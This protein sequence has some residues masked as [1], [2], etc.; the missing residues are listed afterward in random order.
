M[1]VPESVPRAHLP[2]RWKIAK[3]NDCNRPVGRG[4]SGD[5][6]VINGAVML[7]G[8]SVVSE[9]G[10]YVGGHLA[11]AFYNKRTMA[12]K[13]GD[14]RKKTRRISEDSRHVEWRES[15]DV[16]LTGNKRLA[17]SPM[18]SSRPLTWTPFEGWKSSPLTPERRFPLLSF[19][20]RKK[21]HLFPAYFFLSLSLLIDRR[22]YGP[23]FSCKHSIFF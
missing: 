8:K 14:G 15:G 13:I 12:E 4:N 21:H 20:V 22:I 2:R 23:L 6:L 11:T 3:S 19:V 5:C 10:N 9:I 1:R 16:G 7:A 18:H 17:S